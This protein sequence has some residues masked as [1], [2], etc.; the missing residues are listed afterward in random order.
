MGL[1]IARSSTQVLRGQVCQA[2]G[3]VQIGHLAQPS[4]LARAINALGKSF[5]TRAYSMYRRT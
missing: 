1:R 2:D 3:K 5:N 4:V